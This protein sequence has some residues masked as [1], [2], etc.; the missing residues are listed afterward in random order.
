MNEIKLWNKIADDA[1]RLDVIG[2]EQLDF[3]Q[4]CASRFFNVPYEE[5]K[6]EQRKAAKSALYPRMYGAPTEKI[7]ETLSRHEP[8]YATGQ[9][10]PRGHANGDWEGD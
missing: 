1:E 2:R 6:V 5:V 9:P 7:R 3:Y 4:Y 8:Y 10:C